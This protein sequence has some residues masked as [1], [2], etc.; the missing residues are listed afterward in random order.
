MNS[1][2]PPARSSS[3]EGR[4]GPSAPGCCRARR[5]RPASAG[6]AWARGD[7]LAQPHLGRYRSERPAGRRWWSRAR[8]GSRVPLRD[9]G[10]SS[11]VGV[12]RKKL[13]SSGGFNDGS[14]CPTADRERQV[15]V[16]L[17][18]PGITVA[19]RSRPPR[20]PGPC[21]AELERR[22]PAVSARSRCGHHDHDVGGH[23]RRAGAVED[24]PR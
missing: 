13:A 1:A 11:G 20:S 8:A 2:P 21:L 3:G 4:P 24:L 9:R 19:P 6:P 10:C 14:M 15:R 23:R 22:R 5:T 18:Q 7:R 17:H 12:W 16:G